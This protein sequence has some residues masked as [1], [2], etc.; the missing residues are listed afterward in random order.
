MPT[1][2]G[3]AKHLPPIICGDLCSAVNDDA[4]STWQMKHLSDER[5]IDL[6]AFGM[7]GRYESIRY[8]NEIN[9]QKII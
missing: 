7:F 8:S 5:S 1:Q 4:K 2:A 9:A 3:F 6:Y